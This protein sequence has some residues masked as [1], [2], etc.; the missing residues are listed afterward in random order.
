M[1]YSTSVAHNKR[2]TF[3]GIDFKTVFDTPEL[4]SLGRGELTITIRVK[5]LPEHTALTGNLVPKIS[6]DLFDCVLSPVVPHPDDGDG[7][8]TPEVTP[9]TFTRGLAWMSMDKSGALSYK[10]M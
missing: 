1:W 6:C 3:L 5:K 9:A 2:S 8:V 4:E 10:L 7:T